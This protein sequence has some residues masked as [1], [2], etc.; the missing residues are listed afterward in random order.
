VPFIVRWPKASVKAG[1]TCDQ[2]ICNTD[3]FATAAEITGTPLP[4]GSAEDNVIFLPAL[5][6]NTI[7]STRAILEQRCAGCPVEGPAPRREGIPNKQYFG[8]TLDELF[9]IEGAVT[10]QQVCELHENNRYDPAE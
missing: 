1:S 2:L 7:Q 6:G 10:D 8:G 9:I 4:A 5:A 3:L